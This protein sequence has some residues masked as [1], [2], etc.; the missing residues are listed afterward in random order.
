[1]GIQS[2]FIY[3][4]IKSILLHQKMEADASELAKIQHVALMVDESSTFMYPHFKQLQKEMGL[5]DT[6]FS[7]LT[8]KQKKSNY[9]EFKGVVLFTNEVNWKGKITSSEIKQFTDPAY[10]LLIDFIPQ[11]SALKQLIVSQVKAKMKVGYAGNKSDF[12]NIT[13]KVNPEAIEL[14]ITE[15]V[16]YLAILKII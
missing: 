12:Y 3:K 16:K 15:L 13:M 5:D 7:I 9:N 1:M 2:Y 10:D 8:I 4:K 11:N 6:H 14:F